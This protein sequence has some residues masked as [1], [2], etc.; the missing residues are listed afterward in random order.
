MKKPETI[1]ISIRKSN[2]KSAENIFTKENKIDA[3]KNGYIEIHERLFTDPYF[4][5]P[6]TFFIGVYLEN[7]AKKAFTMLSDSYISLLLF[8]ANP[9]SR[10]KKK[11]KDTIEK[12]IEDGIILCDKSYGDGNYFV[13]LVNWRRKECKKPKKNNK[14]ANHKKV[15][16]KYAPEAEIP[17]AQKNPWDEDDA[18]WGYQGS[19]N[20]KDVDEYVKREQKK[21]KEDTHNDSKYTIID[22][23]CPGYYEKIPSYIFLKCVSDNTR[24]TGK[25]TRIKLL[26]FMRLKMYRWKKHANGQR[27]PWYGRLARFSQETAANV[28]DTSETTIKNYISWFEEEELIVVA[29]ASVKYNKQKYDDEKPTIERAPN[30][31]AFKDDISF[32]YLY[33]DQPQMKDQNYKVG[34]QGKIK[35]TAK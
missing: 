14:K 21:K 26:S 28:L 1:E 32:V 19:D 4:E 5:D 27:P 12:M 15:V 13:N 9:N 35:L 31:Y 18:D 7:E 33:I 24:I 29:R 30:L 23:T 2:I 20:M 25:A 16:A 6:V 11:V 8:N 34:G 17:E 22:N 10:Q 3:L